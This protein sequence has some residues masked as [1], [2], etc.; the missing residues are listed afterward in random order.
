[1]PSADG[2]C[3][4]K[5]RALESQCYMVDYVRGFMQTSEPSYDV[6]L[7][8]PVLNE[9]E[10]IEEF[11]MGLAAQ[12]GVSFQVVLCDGGSTDGTVQRVSDL[13]ADIPFPL[14]LVHAEKGRA[15][16]MNA[17]AREATGEYLLFLHADSSFPDSYTLGH[18]T[19]FSSSG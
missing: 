12:R 11:L 14:M 10:G 1:M 8:V 9:V 2:Q 7:I 5:H 3:R 15:H 4:A 19:F 18:G 13:V 6:S 16:Q 17:G